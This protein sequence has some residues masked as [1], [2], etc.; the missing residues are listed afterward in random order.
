MGIF[1]GKEAP[2]RPVRPPAPK[3][4]QPVVAPRPSEAQDT[5]ATC[6]IGAKTTI[7]GEIA[8]EE[9]ILVEG[10]VEGQIRIDRSLTVGSEGTVKATVHAQSVVVRGELIGDCNVAN[11]ME[12]Q[13]TGRLTGSIRAPKIVIAEGAMFKGTSDMSPAGSNAGGRGKAP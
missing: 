12:I 7:R 13:A 10:T 2:V 4:A 5:A 6:V 8:G 11:R 3:P 9:D 1:G